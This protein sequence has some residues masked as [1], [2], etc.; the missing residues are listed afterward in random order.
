VLDSSSHLNYTIFG[1]IF[2]TVYG[3]LLSQTAL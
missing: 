2:A 3:F 1:W